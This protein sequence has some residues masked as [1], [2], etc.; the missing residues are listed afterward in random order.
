MH[1]DLSDEPSNSKLGLQLV[2]VDLAYIQVSVIDNIEDDNELEAPDKKD[3]LE[4]VLSLLVVTY[5]DVL[6]TEHV[7]VFHELISATETLLK[8]KFVSHHLHSF[9]LVLNWVNVSFVLILFSLL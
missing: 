1:D 3:L 4:V 8:T 7:Q 5:T 2:L 6:H 9:H